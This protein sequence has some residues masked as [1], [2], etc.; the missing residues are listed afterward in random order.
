[1]DN[2]KKIWEQELKDLNLPK[3]TPHMPWHGYTLG[4]WPDSW[5]RVSKR[6]VQGQYLETGKEYEKIRTKVSYFEDG[7]VRKPEA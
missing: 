2:A 6:A 1:M 5:D 3:L 4:Y 7:V